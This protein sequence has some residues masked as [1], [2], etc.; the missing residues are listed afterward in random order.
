MA[1][2]CKI[3]VTT[4]IGENVLKTWQW[5]RIEPF[6]LTAVFTKAQNFPIRKRFYKA[7]FESLGYHSK[8]MK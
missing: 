6:S 8:L 4:D 3:L 5:A 2:K 7:D 1:E